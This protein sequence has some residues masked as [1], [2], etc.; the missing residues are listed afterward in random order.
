MFATLPPELRHQIALTAP[1]A[2]YGSGETIVRQGD[3]GQSMFVVLSGSVRVVLE[4]MRTEVAR[5]QRGGYFGEMSLLTGEPRS[6]TVLAVGDVS[7]V[8]IG[9]ELFRRMAALHPDAIEKI[10]VAALERKAGL[11]QVK[12]AAAGAATVATTTLVTRMKKFLGL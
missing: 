1:M 6:A 2:V 11:D 4:P 5:I 9:A 3:A 8:E 12:T 7:A 10:G